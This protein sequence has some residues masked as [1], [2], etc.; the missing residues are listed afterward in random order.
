MIFLFLPP[1]TKTWQG[2]FF[3]PVCD[4]VH[5]EHLCH[6]MHH[7]SHDQGGVLCPGC[8]CPQGLCAGGLCLGDLCLGVSVQWDSVQG[9]LYPGGLCPGGLCLGVSVQA[10]SVQGDLC[11]GGVCLGG[12]CS[13]GS[14]SRRVS[15]QEG[16]CPG[17]L[18]GVS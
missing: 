12:L 2:N 13:E 5:K 7:R 1:A 9:G 18:S 6:C 15:V 14:L 17:S 16:L 10:V 8:L 3:T 4:S 11:L